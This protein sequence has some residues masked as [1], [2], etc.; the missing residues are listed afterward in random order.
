MLEKIL[1]DQDKIPFEFFNWR[2]NPKSQ[3][4]FKEYII[5]VKN[6]NKKLDEFEDTKKHF[7]INSEIENEVNETFQNNLLHIQSKYRLKAKNNCKIIQNG[8][9]KKS[10]DQINLNIL[11]QEIV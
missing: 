4:D 1:L 8:K 5:E 2:Q 10:N 7:E 9:V 11:Q 6:Y 3:E